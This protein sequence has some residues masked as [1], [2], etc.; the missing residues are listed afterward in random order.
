VKIGSYDFEWV[1]DEMGIPRPE[2]TVA[3]QQNL[4]NV[5]FFSWGPQL[6]GKEVV[7]KWKFVSVAQYEAFRSLFLAGGVHV[8]DLTPETI[9][10]DPPEGQATHMPYPDPEHS[11]VYPGPPYRRFYIGSI[12]RL[13]LGAWPLD[14]YIYWNY[15][16]VNSPENPDYNGFGKVINTSDPFASYIEA[17]PD[18]ADPF[19]DWRIGDTIYDDL[20]SKWTVIVPWDPTARELYFYPRSPSVDDKIYYSDCMSGWPS[21]PDVLEVG[22]IVYTDYGETGYCIITELGSDAV[23]TWFKCRA[24]V[25]E[26]APSTL[27]VWTAGEIGST[28]SGKMFNV[29][30]W[31]AVQGG[32]F[33]G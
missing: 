11:G 15:S 7:M 26:W 31:E 22:D 29:V 10:I 28:E 6:I 1:P 18:G 12:H 24:A 8:L 19:P 23:G 27:I 3:V 16:P 5:G 33:G 9:W 13:D 14:E 2:K 25:E 21:V 30:P 32:P 17:A 4:G 20:G